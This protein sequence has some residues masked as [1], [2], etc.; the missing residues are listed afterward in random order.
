MARKAK[1]Y[2]SPEPSVP[3]CLR[4]P[5]KDSRWTAAA[6]ETAAN[7][8]PLLRELD[9][10]LHEEPPLLMNAISTKKQSQI[11]NKG[12]NKPSINLAVCL[13][14]AMS[15]KATYT[16]ENKQLDRTR[17]QNL[18]KKRFIAESVEGKPN[19]RG[20]RFC[21]PPHLRLYRR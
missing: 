17:K 14:R 8:P 3:T 10:S 1:S 4:T 5:P 9:Q 11:R 2:V 19:S 21:P 6:A 18:S 15:R 13:V 16:E 20:H 7:H 12:S